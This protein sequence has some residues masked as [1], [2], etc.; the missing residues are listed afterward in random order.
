[1]AKKQNPQILSPENYIRQRAR[2]LPLHECLLNEKWQ[3]D[4]LAYIII[5]R[6]HI[7]G[8]ITLCFYLVDYKCLGIKDSFFHFNVPEY[9]YKEIK[10]SIG[11][12]MDLIMVE[13]SLVHNI[14]HAAWEYAEDIGFKPVKDFLSVTQYLLE[15]DTDDIPLIDIK[16]GGEDG[17]PLYIRG[18]FDSEVKVAQI[19]NQLEKNL[20][21]DNYNFIYSLDRDFY[22]NGHDDYYY[23]EHDD[24]ENKYETNTL[25]ENIA[26]FFDV[27]NKLK[28][29]AFN[30]FSN[31]DFDCIAN[32]S[33]VADAIYSQI[34]TDEELEEWFERWE[35]E[36][37]YLSISEDDYTA[38]ML[39][40]DQDYSL[41]RKDLDFLDNVEKEEMN[42]FIFE[43]WGNIP[44]Y[45]FLTMKQDASFDEALVEIESLLSLY[46]NYPLFKMNYFIMQSAQAKA[47]IECLDYKAI[48]NNRTDITFCEYELFCKLK[49]SYLIS[50]KNLAGI[51]TLCL[52]I[53]P[54]KNGE[55]IE[56]YLQATKILILREYLL[57]NK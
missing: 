16:C 33:E 39:G 4:R 43:R 13:Y 49:I 23:D 18:P 41:T 12:Q 15:E 17:K 25:E 46:P 26:I 51:Y 21:K 22:E 28:K 9:E 37:K 40:I 45:L 56:S 55:K 32:L 50:T 31:E 52:N 35:E 38:D 34:L 57:N 30:D 29:G 7:N 36:D 6:K 20:G 2:N 8:N 11:S 47:G 19:I 54:L 14:I 24:Y 44:Y 53:S 27:D 42:K 10:E 1:M 48:F 5:S 3:E